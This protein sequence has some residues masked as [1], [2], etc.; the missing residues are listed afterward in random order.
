MM[1]LPG[2]LHE[3][4]AKAVPGLLSFSFIHYIQGQV[5]G[6]GDV[7]N[8]WICLPDNEPTALLDSFC[9]L[10]HSHQVSHPAAHVLVT[11]ATRIT[12]HPHGPR[13]SKAAKHIPNFGTGLIPGVHF[14]CSRE[15]QTSLPSSCGLSILRQTQISHNLPLSSAQT[16]NH[17]TLPG[18]KHMLKNPE[19]TANPELACLFP[20]PKKKTMNAESH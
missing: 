11:M 3:L 9:S 20:G 18:Q 1:T 19:S 2:S 14:P 6:W 5:I 8:T 13:I 16:P 7:T 17:K 4:E 10:W 15:K 12:P